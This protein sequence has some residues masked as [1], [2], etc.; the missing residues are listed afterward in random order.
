MKLRI[1]TSHVSFSALG[2]L[3]DGARHDEVSVIRAYNDY[4]VNVVASEYAHDVQV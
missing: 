1:V 3:I 2:R 4:D